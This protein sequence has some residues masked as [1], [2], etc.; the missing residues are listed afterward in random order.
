[1]NDDAH[2][3]YSLRDRRSNEYGLADELLSQPAELV[4]SDEA[5][6]TYRGQLTWLVLLNVCLRLFRSTTLSVPNARLMVPNAIPH[7]LPHYASLR[8]TSEQLAH[9]IDPFFRP[10]KPTR[11]AIRLA[12]GDV[13]GADIYIGSRHQS[14]YVADTPIP[15]DADHGYAMGTVLAACLG[16]Q[17]LLD[18]L[19]GRGI[20]NKSGNAWHLD[21]QPYDDD[22]Q[23]CTLPALSPG[24]VLQIGAGAVGSNLTYLLRLGG[25]TSEW[26]ICEKDVV[27]LHNTNRSVSFFPWQSDWVGGSY[28][29]AQLSAAQINAIP[30]EA[31]FHETELSDHDLVLP[32]ANEHGVRQQIAN[33]GLPIVFHAT[34]SKANEAQLHRH[35]PHRDDCISCRMPKERAQVQFECSEAPIQ[36]KDGRSIDAALP[37]LSLSAA[38]MLQA[39]LYRLADPTFRASRHNWWRLTFSAREKVF[40]RGRYQCDSSCLGGLSDPVRKRLYVDGRWKHWDTAGCP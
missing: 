35:V 8:A 12:I 6:Q 33:L 28:S 5:A 10:R 31:W 29:K 38:L 30:L 23:P 7:P 18:V 26:S 3:F 19:G 4:I 15:I 13:R 21:D 11:H 25:V 2:R 36:T 24:R 37:H 16:C 34:T 17:A 14:G 32:L 9:A 1:M 40:R 20:Q 22:R 27:K 39:A